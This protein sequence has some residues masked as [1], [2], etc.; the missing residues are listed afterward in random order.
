MKS[1]KIIA[2]LILSATLLTANT[3]AFAAKESQAMWKKNDTGWW[4]E[5]ANG[6]YPQSEWKKIN[7]SWYY[8]GNDGYM[9]ESQWIGNYYVGTN[10][11]MLVNTTTPDGYKVDENGKWIEERQAMWKKND[12]GWWYEN[13]DGSYPQSEWKKINGS[14]YYF[15]NDGYM[16]ESQ[17]IGNYY[18]GTNGAMLVNTT[19]PDGYEVDENGK[20]IEENKENKTTNSYVNGIFYDEN[21]KPANWWYDDG[22]G[23]FFFKDGKKLTGEGTDANGSHY[24]VNGKYANGDFKNAFYENGKVKY[25]KNG[26]YKN[27]LVYKNHVI[28][29]GAFENSDEVK[30]YASR[31]KDKNDAQAY[32]DAGHVLVSQNPLDL[33]DGKSSELEAHAGMNFRPLW[34]SL[35]NGEI[36]TVYDPYGNYSNFKM[37]LFLSHIPNDTSLFTDEYLKKCQKLWHIYSKNEDIGVSFCRTMEYQECWLGE[38]CN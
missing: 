5:N 12:T 9:L 30:A 27:T 28:K 29:I 11:A 26:K 17:W 36:I 32:L 10:G 33:T 34:E 31:R 38:I 35:K 16:L 4:Y 24:F 2:G 37:T 18:V 21:K 22:T 20:W 19:T 6:S 25:Y 23:W 1:K 7:G 14:W 15:G 8:F 3:S 13:T